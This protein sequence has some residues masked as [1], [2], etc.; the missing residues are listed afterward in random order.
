[1]SNSHSDHDSGHNKTSSIIVNGRPREVIEHELSYLQIVQLAF[2]GEQP[3][4]NSVYTVTYSNPHGKDGSMVEGQ[5][6]KIKE[7]MICNVTKT[8]QS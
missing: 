3:A 1:M 7:G 5:D 8:N 2:P 4:P 6:V